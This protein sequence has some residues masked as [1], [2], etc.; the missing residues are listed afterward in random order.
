M[1]K[2]HDRK[3]KGRDSRGEGLDPVLGQTEIAFGPIPE[4]TCDRS[5]VL[6]MVTGL[7]HLRLRAW[8]GA[9]Q[10]HLGVTYMKTVNSEAAFRFA[11][12]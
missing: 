10:S 9:K 12:K 3:T 8:R 5:D 4:W 2:P 1:P 11:V 7:V 6:E